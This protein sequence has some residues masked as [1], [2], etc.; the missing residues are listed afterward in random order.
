MMNNKKEQ[1]FSVTSCSNSMA[2]LIDHQY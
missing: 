1:K 2:L